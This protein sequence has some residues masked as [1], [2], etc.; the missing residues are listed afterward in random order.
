M[1]GIHIDF[2]T[3]ATVSGDK[4][5]SFVTY[6]WHNKGSILPSL[7]VIAIAFVEETEGL[8]CQH[9]KNS[10]PPNNIWRI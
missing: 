5:L 8:P 1:Q 4:R 6:L 7:P 9:K 10:L 3:L 2:T